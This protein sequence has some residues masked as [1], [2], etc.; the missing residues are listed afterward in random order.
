MLSRVA[1]HFF[2]MGRYLERTE[3]TARLVNVNTHLLLD[4]PKGVSL[5]WWPLIEITGSQKIFKEQYAEPSEKLVV[6]FLVADTKNTG[7]LS[8]SLFSA[9]ENARAVRDI[10][11]SEAWEAIN[12]LFDY[13][14]DS[15]PSAI[16]RK[17][18]FIFLHEVISRNQ[19]ICGLLS[20][21][22]I[23][24][25]GYDFLRLGHA[26]ERADM[27]TRNVDVRSGSL[28]TSVSE[29]LAPFEQFQWLSI[30]QSMSAYQ[31]YRQEVHGTIRRVSVLRF[32]MQNKRFPRSFAYSIV[33]A[34]NCL[35]DLPHNSMAMAKV[36][37]LLDKVDSLELEKLPQS[38]LYLTLDELQVELGEL[39]QIITDAYF[40]LERSRKPV[41]VTQAQTQ[42]AA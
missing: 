27:T 10:I 34:K 42:S 15:L 37:A 4:L 26:L 2:W 24:N 7:S 32:L 19:Q 3:N 6:K 29:D 9:R 38:S 23:H 33:E 35:Q 17:N 25:T 21:T 16:Y 8:S 40:S 28:L 1:E 11:P 5:G 36:S 18:R 20:G 13:V 14:K 31:A 22:M 41:K 39:S 30:L 12:E